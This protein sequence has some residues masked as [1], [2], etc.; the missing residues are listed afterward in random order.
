VEVF[1]NI[2]CT[3]CGCLCDDLRITVEGGRICRAEGACR[4]SEPWYLGQESREPPVGLI[5]GRPATLEAAVD[6][7]A[8][9]LRTAS[10]PL[11][12]GMSR[13]STEGQRAAISLAECIGATVD[14]TA[15]LCHAPS[16]MALQEVGEST[17]TLGEV[18][19]R[20]D[21]VIY[22]G[23]D[24]I[25]THPRHIERYSLLPPGKFTPGGRSDRKL[26]VADM[27]P[28]ATTE[29]ADFFLP[30]EPGRDFEALVTLRNLVRGV[31]VNETASAGAPL[32]QLEEL[33]RLMK[34]CRFG[35]VFFGLGLSM[36]GPGQHNVEA[37]L[38]LVRDL[39]E[40]TRFFARR[41]RIQGDVSGADI[42]LTWQTG[43][44]FSVNLARGCPRYNPGE[45]SAH[46][47]LERGDVDACLFLGSEG[48]S[49]FSDRAKGHLSQIPWV[50]LDYPTLGSLVPP[51]VR[52]TTAVYGI[53]SR[54]TAYRMD[55]IPIP[56]QSFLPTKYPT[57]ADVLTMIEEQLRDGCDSAHR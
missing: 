45:F 24:P 5:E 3:I 42:V 56:L 32:R 54:G 9:I 10:S 28:T 20:A 12:Y 17:C 13:S 15:S 44:P 16:V 22:W 33:A 21:L 30:V 38:L 57:D 19:N 18:K 41:M 40:Y 6:R 23:S 46:E 26:V 50:T 25:V 7:A 53:H 2:A 39:N 47:M 36:T 51:T 31:P 27:Q 4:L 14:T 49:Q 52:F 37:L 34:S 8:N 55:G 11:V 43:Y 48:V 1:E 35:I 29:L